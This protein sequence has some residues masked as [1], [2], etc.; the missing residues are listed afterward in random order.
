LL[1]ELLEELRSGSF[2]LSL[3]QD[4]LRKSPTVQNEDLVSQIVST[5]PYSMHFPP[6][7]YIQPTLEISLGDAN[8]HNE[9]ISCDNFVQLL[10]SEKSALAFKEKEQ[11]VEDE[12]K[13]YMI[14]GNMQLD[15][16]NHTMSSKLFHDRSVS[17]KLII[18]N[19]DLCKH[20][21]KQNVCTWLLSSAP[22]MGKSMLTQKIATDLRINFPNYLMVSV[23]LHDYRNYFA[24]NRLSQITVD[25]FLK[26]AE[27]SQNYEIML[28]ENKIVFVFDGFDEICPEQRTKVLKLIKL[29]VGRN[30]P[31]WISTRPQEEEEIKKAF[32]DTSF[33]SINIKVL[34]KAEQMNLIELNSKLPRS[35]CLE[36]FDQINKSGTADLMENPLHLT[37][38]TQLLDPKSVQQYKTKFDLYRKICRQ[39]VLSS[40][41]EQTI[42]KEEEVHLLRISS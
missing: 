34:R 37:L 12:Q 3:L 4:L 41:P 10:K 15:P 31:L 33:G 7:I 16:A 27:R 21:K 29:I 42:E 26:L 40:L 32:T 22:G 19:S 14:K 2:L 20:L 9:V 5:L 24:K 35:K 39:K 25:S 23:N 6:H 28:E 36:F 8:Q 13:T 1:L 38:I 18:K 11:K 30:I 17:E